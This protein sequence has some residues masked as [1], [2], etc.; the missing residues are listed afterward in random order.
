[1]K[2][3]CNIVLRFVSVFC[4][5]YN[6]KYLVTRNYFRK[7]TDI[8]IIIMNGDNVHKIYNY[9]TAGL[10]LRGHNFTHILLK[11]GEES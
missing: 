4:L 5:P 7:I 11:M 3:E 2:Q 1:M 10:H 8:N 6:Y 9:D